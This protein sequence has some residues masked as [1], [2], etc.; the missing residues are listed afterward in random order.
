MKGL[1][2]NLRHF[3]RL[4]P[5]QRRV[6]L[7]A[8]VLLPVVAG[9]LRFFG[10]SGALELARR[11]AMV[12]RRPVND[13]DA[14]RC[15]QLVAAAAACFPLTGNCLRESIVL[16]TILRRHSLPAGVYVGVRKRAHRLEAHA[17]VESPEIPQM[18]RQS[19]IHRFLRFSQPILE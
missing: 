10:T 19:G 9:T 4:A 14:R 6:A 8:Y 12:N 11:I 2:H 3:L 7:Q 15:E 13:V 5:A 18:S 1:I 17:W 16:Y